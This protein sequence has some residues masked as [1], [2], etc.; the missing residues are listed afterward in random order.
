M[1]NTGTGVGVIPTQGQKEEEIA[2]EEEAAVAEEEEGEEEEEEGEEEEEE[3]EEEGEEGE[4]E[5]E[6]YTEMKNEMYFYLK[7]DTSYQ[8][9]A[10]GKWQE[11]SA[12]EVVGDA[13][14]YFHHIL[15][16]RRCESVRDCFTGWSEQ[17]KKVAEKWDTLC[18]GIEE[19]DGLEE[20]ICT[21]ESFGV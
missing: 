18:E 11:N 3:G 15:T 4:E 13:D 2:A 1:K 20:I 19:L 21:E 14:T 10:E 12:G 7:S 17:D 8:I 6:E 9:W 5:D 16:N